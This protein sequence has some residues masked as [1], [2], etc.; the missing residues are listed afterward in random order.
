[1]DDTFS[2]CSQF[3]IKLKDKLF[4]ILA[5]TI[6]FFDKHN[7]SWFACGGTMLGAV[8]HNDIIPWDD[9]IDLMMP[10]KDY[11][12]LLS[13]KQE[14]SNSNYELVSINDNGY[15]LT[16]AKIF[17][18]RTT[19]WE[20]QRYEYVIGA[21]VDIFPLDMTDLNIDDY[22]QQHAVYSKARTSYQMALSNFTISEMLWD[23]K[24]RHPNAFLTG[25]Q[26]LFY[27]KRSLEKKHSALLK[28]E[29]MFVDSGNRYTISPSGA[30][31]TR[32]YFL[33]EWFND[34]IMFPFRYL[35]VRV[36]VGYKDYLT[37][38][39]GDYLQMPPEN[40]RISHHSQ[41][42]VNLSEALTI[43]EVKLRIKKG[44]SKYEI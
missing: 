8:R 15:Y 19:I 41:Y 16:S 7:I 40:K 30:Y 34:F 33:S 37:V 32:E 9:D 26:S 14:F 20:V 27:S 35:T 38:M 23:F 39:Y 4:N 28:I 18:K 3:D 29:R 10:R 43:N 5:F 36:P 25:V 12:K 2:T 42:Y 6:D 17:D 24:N 22:K 13:L 31:G 1:M 21:F 44:N 11:D